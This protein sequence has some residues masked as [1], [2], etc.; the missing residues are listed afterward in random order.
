MHKND[1]GNK[2]LD[3]LILMTVFLLSFSI[4]SA[5]NTENTWYR[6]VNST[7]ATIN[8]SY[9]NPFDQFIVENDHWFDLFVPTKT[10]YELLTFWNNTPSNVNIYTEKEETNDLTFEPDIVYYRAYSE[11]ECDNPVSETIPAWSDYI[12]FRHYNMLEITVPVD[13]EGYL[14]IRWM[15][16][17]DD[18]MNENIIGFKQ[19]EGWS[20]VT[21][22]VLLDLY[23]DSGNWL[24]WPDY[25]FDNDGTDDIETFFMPD[26]DNT[27]T[28]WAEVWADAKTTNKIKLFAGT[29]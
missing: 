22:S 13:I 26:G 14:N 29:N 2:I 27:D 18:Q 24:N 11:N 16:S 9:T 12:S 23:A 28:W 1:I 4:T 5:I 15:Y 19:K 20:T 25:D 21:P 6:S 17:W 10:F 7:D 3:S 8:L